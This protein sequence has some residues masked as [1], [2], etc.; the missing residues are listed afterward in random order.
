MRK[1]SQWKHKKYPKKIYQGNYGIDSKK[2]RVFILAR[3]KD[4]PHNVTFESHEAAKTLGWK[5]VK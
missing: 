1:P 3:I 5:K 4:R 2:E